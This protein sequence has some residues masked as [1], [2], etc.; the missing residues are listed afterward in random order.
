MS[1]GGFR[2]LMLGLRVEGV[3]GGKRS[4]RWHRADP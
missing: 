3:R 1:Y 4:D 2:L